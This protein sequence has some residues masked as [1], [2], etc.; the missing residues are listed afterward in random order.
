MTANK[1]SIS[2]LAELRASGSEDKDDYIQALY[3]IILRR[4]PDANGLA[5]YRN[6]DDV[7][8][9]FANFLSS[10]EFRQLARTPAYAATGA[11]GLST[12]PRV[13]LFGAYGNGNLGDTIQAL[14]L[15]QG[16]QCIRPDIEIWACSVLRSPFPFPYHRQLSSEAILNPQILNSFDMLLIGGGGLLAH[17]HEP[18]FDPNWQSA[19]EVPICFIGVGA[20]ESVARKSEIILKRASYVSARDDQSLEA[21]R[22]IVERVEFVP[23]PVLCDIRYFKPHV[24]T[25]VENEPSARRLWILRYVDAPGFDDLYRE[26][27]SYGDLVCFFEP[28]LDFRIVRHIPYAKP[29]YCVEHAI[30]MIDRADIVLSM[31]FHGCILSLLRGKITFGLYEE[32]CFSLLQRYRNERWFSRDLTPNWISPTT[33]FR[34]VTNQILD[35]RYAFIQ[36]LWSALSLVRTSEITLQ[37]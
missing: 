36:G 11:L 30:D 7:E 35:D 28:Q 14:S 6:R 23:D 26:I 4:D 5:A 19:V 24:G 21:L 2:T 16:I 12:G 31:R 22:K 8:N 17:P 10:A 13:L 3:R 32:K 34:A 20:L 33:A 9:F 29:I 1:P 25:Y 27:A 15:A 37:F 18:L